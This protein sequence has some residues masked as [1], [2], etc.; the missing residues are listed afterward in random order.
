MYSGNSGDYGYLPEMREI[1]DLKMVIGQFEK[2]DVEVH[3]GNGIDPPEIYYLFENGE[4]IVLYPERG[5]ATTYKSKKI[6]VCAEDW[7]R[8]FGC[9][10]Y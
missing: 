5:Y 4:T 1:S 2:F 10:E 3:R 9:P 7:V 6:M 8:I